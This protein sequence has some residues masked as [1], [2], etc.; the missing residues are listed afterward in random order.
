M[1]EHRGFPAQDF[2]QNI[3]SSVS[4]V[5]WLETCNAI[6]HNKLVLDEKELAALRREMARISA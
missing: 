2:E 4:R 1:N 6:L 3:G 5:A